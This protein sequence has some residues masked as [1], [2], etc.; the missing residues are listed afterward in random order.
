MEKHQSDLRKVCSQDHVPYG[1]HWISRGNGGLQASP[2]FFPSSDSLQQGVPS[3]DTEW[4]GLLTRSPFPQVTCYC[5]FVFSLSW[6]SKASINKISGATR[7]IPER[8]L[9]HWS[10]LEFC[11]PSWAPLVISW[12]TVA[13]GALQ[14]KGWSVL[15]YR[16]K[17]MGKIMN[18]WGGP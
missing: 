9:L 10:P 15:G 4:S 5:V 18:F 17:Q 7:A 6:G 14:E 11:W 13:V 2:S 12:W 3:R 16:G 8:L 1:E